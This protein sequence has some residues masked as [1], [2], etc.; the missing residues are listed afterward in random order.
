MRL[1]PTGIKNLTTGE[2][3]PVEYRGGMA[4]K[5]SHCYE[6]S[7]FIKPNTYYKDVKEIGVYSVICTGSYY[8]YYNEKGEYIDA[9]ND[10]EYRFVF[11]S[12]N[13]KL[14]TDSTDITFTVLT[15]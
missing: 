11:P 5:K 1:P 4:L 6:N 12:E 10:E 9:Y 8:I 7:E 3:I 14:C 13:R 2:T 15:N